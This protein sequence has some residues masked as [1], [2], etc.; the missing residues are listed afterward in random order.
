MDSTINISDSY[1]LKNL[2]LKGDSS[3]YNDFTKYFINVQN[4]YSKFNGDVLVASNS[5]PY[6]NN[7]PL[8]SI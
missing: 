7:V 2:I 3:K 5:I 1:D 6:Y 8:P 4:T